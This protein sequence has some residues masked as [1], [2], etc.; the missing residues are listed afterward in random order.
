MS[1]GS[2]GIWLLAAGFVLQGVGW[3][4]MI[5]RSRAKNRR[6]ASVIDR[7]NAGSKETFLEIAEREYVRAEAIDSGLIVAV[8]DFDG[9]SQFNTERGF[10]Q[11]DHAIAG[12]QNELVRALRR[13]DTSTYLGA[14]SW[15]VLLPDTAASDA[16]TALSKLRETVQ[17]N[18]EGMT[19]SVGYAHTNLHSGSVVDL[20]QT[21]DQAML[22]AQLQG[23]N[24]I[25]CWDDK[26]R[27]LVRRSAGSRRVQR[28]AQ[29]ST[30]LSLAEALDLRD[31]D[32][33]NH[34]RMVGYYAELM[35]QELGMPPAK[36]ERVR[37]AGLLHDI[38][39]IGVPD[40]VLRKPSKLDDD[41]WE[42]MKRHPEIGARLLASIDAEDIRTWVLAHHER[43]DGRGY[44]FA[45]PNDDIPLEAK[46]LSVADAYEA[47]TSDRVY[48]AAPGPEFARS[49]L[50]KWKSAQFDPI[51]VEAFLH[52]LKHIESE[53]E[54]VDGLEELGEAA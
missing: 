37:I 29:L 49:E 7:R 51:V 41:E 40:S 28:D 23:G 34:S 30:V 27:D 44:P 15:A 39:K 2:T 10:K 19:L 22:A 9:L 36:V 3:W 54:V 13:I 14:G 48:R 38:G 18:T 53:E 45:L 4:L 5:S 11:G 16:G 17:R 33:S 8:F 26:K 25:E 47:M 52:V 43:P 20:L 24:R 6:T 12:V 32:T 50:E 1:W 31:A 46:I 35:A 42:M 21:A